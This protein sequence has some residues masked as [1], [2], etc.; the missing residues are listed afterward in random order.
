ML[1]MNWS[2][3]YDIPGEK[4]LTVTGAQ[5]F[6]L[7][8]VHPCPRA[9][10][11]VSVDGKLDEWGA[12]GLVCREP[13][14]VQMD[15]RCWTGPD[16]ASFEFAVS[17]DD[18]YVYVAVDCVD[19]K[20]V[21]DKSRNARQ[22]DGVGIFVDARDA[23]ARGAGPDKAGPLLVIACPTEDPAKPMIADKLPEGVK[24]ACTLTPTG[25]RRRSRSRLNTSTRS[26]GSR[27]RH[28]G[29]TCGS[30]TTTASRLAQGSYLLAAELD[31]S[32][33]LQGFRDVPES[34]RGGPGVLVR[35][36]RTGTSAPTVITGSKLPVPHEEPFSG[37]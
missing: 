14:L 4:P 34:S 25:M 21:L 2:V 22:Q 37:E 9:A 5:P 31:R 6:M 16:D 7:E 1:H 17:Y 15:R 18:D 12:L 32:D 13:M 20:I 36:G 33:E 24:V 10:K 8:T 23:E 19:D 11:P 29:S 35:P 3:L 30:R 26:R 27:G 28:S